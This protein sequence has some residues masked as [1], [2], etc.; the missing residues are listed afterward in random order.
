V[1]RFEPT[2]EEIAKVEAAAE[3]FLSELDA[4]FEAFTQAAA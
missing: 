4:M 1:R 3:Q 2:A